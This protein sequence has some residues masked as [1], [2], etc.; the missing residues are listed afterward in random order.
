[1]SDK[2]WTDKELFSHW[3]K[4]LFMKHIPPTC[5]VLFLLDGHSSHYEP[6][7]IR[8]AAAEGVVIFCCDRVSNQGEESQISS[9][10]V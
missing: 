6:D 4:D 1:M 10:S 5:P 7:T 8:L 9:A 3:I 2:G